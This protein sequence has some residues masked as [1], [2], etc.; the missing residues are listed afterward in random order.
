MTVEKQDRRRGQAG[1]RD[2]GISRGD[3]F[4]ARE[5]R[6]EAVTCAALL[7]GGELDFGVDRRQQVAHSV[8]VSATLMQPLLQMLS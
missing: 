8:F 7:C 3:D 6:R 2:R 1:L 4:R 5:C